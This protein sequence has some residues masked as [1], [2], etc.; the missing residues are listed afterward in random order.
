MKRILLG[1]SGLLVLTACWTDPAGYGEPIGEQSEA[2]SA[3]LPNAYCTIKVTGVG[4]IS[5]E[6]DYLPHVIQ[7]EN[8]G[9]NLQALK[10]QA[11]AAR[12]VAYYNMAT[13]GSICDSQGCQVYSCGATPSAIH[14]QAVKETAGVYLSY[15]GMLTY[16]FFVAG[17]SGVKPPSCV[18]SSGSTE[19]WVTYNDGK[20]GTSVEQTALGYIG[21]PGYGQNR[22]CMSQWGARCLENSKGYD[23]K[24]ILQFFYGADIKFL[25][26]PGSCVNTDKSP[27]GY[28]D[29]ADCDR[30]AGWAQDEDKANTPI[31]VHLY[32]GGPAGDANA[33][34]F[35]LK[36]DQ[37]RDDLCGAIG[38][39][40]HGFEADSPLS[41]HDGQDH[42]VHA[43][44]IDA[45]GGENS[46]LSSS[47][48]ALRCEPMIPDGV[49][50][51]VPNPAVFTAWQFDYFWDVMP[52]SDAALAEHEE[53]LPV[54]AQPSLVKADDGSASVYLL[55]SGVKRHVPSPAVMDSWG[56][57]WG[58]IETRPAADLAQLPDGPDVRSRPVLVQGSGSAVYLVD[59]AL[60]TDG[61]G[62]GGGGSGGTGE[63]G[64]SAGATSAGGSGGQPV[65]G[66]A[67]AAGSEGL[68]PGTNIVSDDN[69]CACSTVGKRRS[70]D[71]GPSLL[72]V[73]LAGLI[74]R[75]RRV[76]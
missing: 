70:G 3:P 25:T 14:Y 28:L 63:A 32:F 26:S 62:T 12:S 19:H 36:A 55:D 37:Y 57:D 8:G 48:K 23:Y 31:D 16:G 11:I 43:Y 60:P 59:D 41:L 58:A 24:R 50:R 76:R 64:G 49:L 1:C 21:P 29:A 2:V 47:P 61:G 71:L 5:M 39:C 6:D 44:G 33:K 20:T 72:L 53:A 9:A 42:A 22:G 56:F 38:S 15:G 45:S 54:Q 46:Q 69:G 51:H 67:G 52:V 27:R 66:A 74:R 7:C 40:E 10:A 65:G 18:G 73:G 68:K 30:V 4:T 75:R 35:A 34:S 13:Q 17:D